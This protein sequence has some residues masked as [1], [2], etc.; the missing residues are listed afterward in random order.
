MR[1]TLDLDELQHQVVEAERELETLEAKRQALL[2]RR[3]DL[4][5]LM[6]L[7]ARLYGQAAPTSASAPTPP[8][9]P[10]ES[11][12]KELDLSLDDTKKAIR[13]V[14]RETGRPWKVKEL[15]TELLRLGWKPRSETDDPYGAV[16]TAISR[17]HRTD[18]R[19][20]KPQYGFYAW[21][22][23]RAAA[24]GH[25]PA[26]DPDDPDDLSVFA[27]APEARM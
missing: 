26:N 24:N 12:A 21:A 18:L 11:P 8:T 16:N 5:G 14:L 9:G 7:T 23:D 25:A 10:P 1:V 22:E 27:N 4:R 19:V 13:R 20:A 17:L 2:Q 6:E 3:S 15:T